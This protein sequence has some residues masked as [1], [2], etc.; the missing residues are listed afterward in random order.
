MGA[1][2]SRYLFFD[3][4]LFTNFI[5]KSPYHVLSKRFW[6]GFGVNYRKPISQ[7]LILDVD[8]A[9]T[10][11]IIVDKSDEAKYDT[12]GW[13]SITYENIYQGLQLN[14]YAK[15]EYKTKKDFHPF[16]SIAV[17]VPVINSLARAAADE[18]YHNHFKGQLFI[19]AGIGYFLK[20]RHF[21][22]PGIK[23]PTKK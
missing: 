21:I 16:L 5:D 4:R 18:P 12:A 6:G 1:A 17:A 3:E 19:G 9:P 2:A 7:K 22:D 11:L 20:T 14:L 10:I 8:V 15:L 13:S 23:R